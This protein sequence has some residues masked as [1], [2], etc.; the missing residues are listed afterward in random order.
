MK[1]SKKE[2]A[3]YV[4]FAILLLS[5]LA[6]FNFYII[7]IESREPGYLTISITALAVFFLL[8][9]IVR[10]LKRKEISRN[11]MVLFLTL[12]FSVILLEKA[13]EYSNIFPSHK[14]REMNYDYDRV[15]AL[16]SELN[17]GNKAHIRNSPKSRQDENNLFLSDVTNEIT[18][19]G[20]EDSGMIIFKSDENG[21]R[22]PYGSY[23]DFDVLLLGPSHTESS[24]VL[25]NETMH[26]NLTK[27]GYKAYNAAIGGTGLVHSLATFIEYGVLKKPKFVILQIIE[28]A[29]IGRM[30]RE[31]KNDKLMEYYKKHESKGLTSKKTIQN[32]T[33]RNN[34]NKKILKSYELILGESLGIINTENKSLLTS[35]FPQ[36]VRAVELLKVKFGLVVVYKGEGVPVCSSIGESRLRLENILKFFQEK[37]NSF[38]GN[39]IVNYL[40]ATRYDMGGRKNWDN[41]EY[42]MVKSLLNELKIPLIDMVK[43]FDKSNNLGSY[44]AKNFYRKD[45]NGHYSAIG[46][47]A[48][49]DKIIEHLD[50]ANIN[51]GRVS[52]DINTK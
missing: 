39:F 41:C 1:V 20:E 33:I 2:S 3:V 45:I 48:V 21:F 31:F 42:E 12:V 47:K 7:F 5:L 44:F 17:R 22:N 16:N 11:Y 8:H 14:N 36:I 32:D 24:F 37:T 10:S 13:M 6:A 52:A 25:D 26:Y 19:F 43:E 40:G 18:I 34:F 27:N 51:E 35:Y 46:Y 30:N 15:Q 28:G 4:V 38:G 49:S 9:W 50:S 23:N 29:S